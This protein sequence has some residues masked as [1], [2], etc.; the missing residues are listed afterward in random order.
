MQVNASPHVGSLCSSIDFCNGAADASDV[1]IAVTVHGGC[2][3]KAEE[4]FG[5]VDGTVAVV[6]FVEVHG[7]YA[8][9]VAAL[10]GAAEEMSYGASLDVSIGVASAVGLG[11]NSRGIVGRDI[12]EPDVG[13]G[14]AFAGSVAAAEEPAYFVAS[15]HGDVGLRH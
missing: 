7:G 5:D 4:F 1:H 13:A 11:G 6:G 14:V 3:T 2:V 10:V 12:N 9:Y 15:V 8:H